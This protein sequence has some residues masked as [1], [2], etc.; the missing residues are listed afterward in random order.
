MKILNHFKQLTLTSDQS[1][2]L[3]LV[4]AFLEN[5]DENIFLLKGYAGSGKTTIL[6]GIVD[7]LK[8]QETNFQLMAP[9]GRAAKVINHKTQK[10]ASTIH[11]GIYSFEDLEEIEI[12]KENNDLSFLYSFKIR[13]NSELKNS[14]IIIDEA[15]MISDVESNRF[16][17]FRF[18]SGYLLK[19]LIEYAKL[20]YNNMMIFVGDPAQLPPI[21]MNHSPALDKTYLA[22]KYDLKVSEVTIKEVIRQSQDNGIYKASINLR[23]SITSGYFN[24]FDL[25]SNGKD[26]EN[27]KFEN[28][29]Q[30]YANTKGSKIVVTYQNKIAKDINNDIRFHKYKKQLPIQTTD[31]IIIGVNNYSLNIMNGEFG[32]VNNVSDQLTTREI[33]Y[34]E[35]DGKGAVKS[36]FL[37]WRKIELIIPDGNATD[38]VVSSY[39]LDNYLNQDE[40]QLTPE[41]QRALYVDFKTRNKGLTEGTQAFKDALSNDS[42][43]NAIKLKYA[44]AVTCHK[45]QGGEWENTFTFWDR[46]AGAGFKEQAHTTE[47]KTN[48]DFYRWAYTAVT[49]AS[50]K[51]FCINPPYFTPYNN[52]VI[53]NQSVLDTLSELTN[54]D[55]NTIEVDTNHIVFEFLEKYN[56]LNEPIEI[57]NHFIK[58]FI[59][60]RKQY[61]DIT[62]W[63]RKSQYEIWFN[64]STENEFTAIKFSVNGKNK[65][66]ENY[67]PQLSAQSNSDNLYIEISNLIK[68]PL[69]LSVKRDT[70]ETTFPQ[71][72]FDLEVEE[73]RPFLKQ[74]YNDLLNACNKSDISV[75]NVN[76]QQYRERYSFQKGIDTAVIDFV[77]DGKGFFGTVV[78]LEKKC[79]SSKLNSSLE[80]IINNLKKLNND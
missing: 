67:S 47:A 19:D 24:S 3:E 10:E 14:V 51:L 22:E 46:G 71:I 29:L 7:Y 52:L 57:Q 4:S 54:V 30:T 68:T 12:R 23:Q 18:G 31:L 59:Q 72:E 63:Q 73:K 62:N 35:K 15:S 45:A 6:K 33:R 37:N 5:K 74:I 80:E 69:N 13:E 39:M 56:L 21:G 2:A 58:I 1:K 55:Q 32:V 79:K 65:I 27:I 25:S 38:K 75:L 76:H 50:K 34:Y 36:V 48:S 49:R 28:F 16:E 42:F 9:T 26:I 17:F 61:I 53:V 78:F 70:I 66:K 44:Y 40:G 11:R 77:Y 64:F 60:V 41:V 8:E 43:F 20:H